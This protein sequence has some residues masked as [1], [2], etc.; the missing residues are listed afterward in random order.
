MQ[1]LNNNVHIDKATMKVSFLRRSFPSVFM[2]ANVAK[3]FWKLDENV[4]RAV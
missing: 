1:V 3:I 4:L 2:Q